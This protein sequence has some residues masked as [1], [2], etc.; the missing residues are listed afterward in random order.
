[1]DGVSSSE[2]AAT[3]IV[4][5]P[6][7]GSGGSVPTAPLQ[8][9]MPLLSPSISSNLPV[10]VAISSGDPAAQ[11]YYTTDGTVPTPASPA[12]ATPLNFTT[13]TTLRAV[14]YRAGY[15]PSVSAVGDYVPVLNTNS[16]TVERSLSG[17]GLFIPSVTLSAKPSPGVGCYSVTEAIAPGL[18]PDGL[19][20]NAVWNPTSHTIQWEPFF[21]TNPQTLTYQLIGSSGTY[22]LA[23]QGSFD[24]YSAGVTGA[25]STTID[26]AYSGTP[27]TTFPTCAT[28]PLAYDINI[29]PAPNLIAVTS[30]SG[31]VNWGDGTQ[32]AITQPVMTLQKQYA[33]SGTYTITITANWTGFTSDT[34]IS[35][36]A[37][38]TDTVRAVNQCDPVIVSGPSNEVVVAGSTAQFS[39]NATS[40]FPMSYQWYF[41]SNPIVS[42]ATF[43]TLTLPDVLVPAGGLYSVVVSNAYGSTTSAATLT[44]LPGVTGVSLNANGNVVLTLAALPNSTSRVWATTNLSPLVVWQVISTDNASDINGEWQFTDTNTVSYPLRYYRFSTP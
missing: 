22:P 41:E 42:P 27:N 19:P 32:S 21:G 12:Y 36:Q 9:P 35:G 16:L 7:A 11:I 28:E 6:T 33:A 18:M 3:T 13:R 5:A 10:T 37:T 25:A 20:T 34:M 39:V 17:D 15:L 14:A 1:V 29:N 26:A 2:A 30:A 38:K 43:A 44:V 31:T 8:E 4:V 24:G 23:G 40:I